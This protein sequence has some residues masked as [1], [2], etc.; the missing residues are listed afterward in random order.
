[1]SDQMERNS[2]TFVNVKSLLIDDSAMGILLY[3]AKY[4]PDVSYQEILEKFGEESKDALAELKHFDMVSER[5]SL[6]SLTN[7]GLFQVEGFLN[8]LHR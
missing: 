3:L 6:L 1:M 2:L 7:Y 5:N 8:L 4:N